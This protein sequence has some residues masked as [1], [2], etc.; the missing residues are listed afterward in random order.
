[1]DYRLDKRDSQLIQALSAYKS[2]IYTSIRAC[3]EDFGVARSTLQEQLQKPTTASL[4]QEHRQRLSFRQEKWLVNWI[5]D[6]DNRAFPPSHARAREMATRCL[7]QNGDFQPLGKKWVDGFRRRNPEVTTLIGKR[8]DSARIEGAIPEKMTAYFERLKRVTDDLK[9]QT[10]NTYNMDET[11]TAIGASA[12]TA[13]LGSSV[14][15]TA[16][17]KA[18]GDRE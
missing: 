9:I 3:A 13:V 17:V 2:G 10:C 15:K 12:N 5:L 11:G 7:A 16:R 14:K 18:P 1:M 8:I 6:E 4:G